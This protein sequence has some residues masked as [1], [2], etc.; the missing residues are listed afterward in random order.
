MKR[1]VDGLTIGVEGVI[2]GVEGPIQ[3]AGLSTERC[4]LWMM[5]LSVNKLFYLS[6]CCFL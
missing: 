1:S 4:R 3:S 6:R 5:L 2:S